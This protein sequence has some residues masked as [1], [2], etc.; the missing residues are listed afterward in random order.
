MGRIAKNY[1]YNLIYQ[2]FSMFVPLITA[3]YLARTLG[4]NGTGI[5]GYVNSMTTLICTFV[6]LGIYNYGNRQIAYVRDDEE[7]LSNT[8]WQVMSSRIV[9]AIFGTIVYFVITMS[10]GKYRFLF[11]IYYT[12]M[13]GYFIDPTWLFVGVEDMKWALLKNMLTKI[14]AVAGIFLFVKNENGVSIYLL[15]QGLSIAI[16]N[17][18]S[19][20]QIKRYVKKAH[21]DFSNVKS[22]ILNSALL[23]LPSVGT[24][25]YTQ[26]D[27]IML[28]LMTG[29][30]NSVAFYDYSEKL[31]T[32]PLAFITAISTVM[33]PR[34]ANEFKNENKNIIQELLNKSAR[35]SLFIAFPVMFGMIAISDKLVPWYLGASF[36]PTIRAIKIMAPILITNTLIGISGSQ[37]F[38]ATNQIKV[39]IISQF[40]AAILNI[41]V[42]IMLIPQYSFMGATVATLLTS[43]VSVCIQFYYMLKQ[44]KLPNIFQYGFSCAAMSIIMYVIILVVTHNFPATVLTTMLQVIIGGGV[45]LGISILRKDPLVK[46]ILF[47]VLKKV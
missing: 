36:E 26:C 24:V 29:N 39:L 5:Y 41:F 35:Y 23:F 18:L 11:A 42:N 2:S 20:T 6:L 47:K 31:I 10:L 17:A 32:I 43:C 9:I 38:T 15:I 21:F 16:A 8:F 37:F 45:Y 13:I 7:A 22:D 44:I 12:Y 4:P 3:P 46:E 28:E 19:F 30:S 14:I 25:I 33:M 34:I 1:I 40:S 27:K